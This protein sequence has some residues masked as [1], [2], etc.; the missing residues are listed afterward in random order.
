MPI[1]VFRLCEETGV[2][3]NSPQPWGKYVNFTQKGPWL[4]SNQSGELICL[5]YFAIIFHVSDSGHSEAESQVDG[6]IWIEFL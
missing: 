5:N 2:P 1:H 3:R 6:A 4:A